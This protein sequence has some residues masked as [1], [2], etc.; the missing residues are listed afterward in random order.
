M[1][2]ADRIHIMRSSLVA[3]WVKDL[4]LLLLWLWL[5]LRLGFDLWP[6]NFCMPWAWPKKVLKKGKKE[7]IS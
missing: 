7:F 4:A 3:Q 6:R 5:Q 2:L 1:T